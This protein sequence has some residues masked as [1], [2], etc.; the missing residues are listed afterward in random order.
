MTLLAALAVLGV[1]ATWAA[2]Q[3]FNT[4]LPVATGEFVF[5]EQLMYLNASDDPSPADRSLHV[6]G[7]ISVLGFGVTP[8]FA[9]FGAL[10]YLDK[11]LDI[12][13]PGLNEPAT[14][15]SSGLGDMRLFG[16]YTVFQEDARGRTFRI[17]PLF[18]LEVPSGEDDERDQLGRLPAPLQP[19]RGAR[20]GFAG[21][22]VTYQTLDYQVD[23]QLSYE[24]NAE[25]NGFELGDELRLD[26]SLQYRLWPREL[27]EGV[28]GFLYGVIE[29]NFLQQ[30]ENALAGLEDPNSGGRS[31]HLSPGVQYVTQRW[32]VE[33]I[34]QIPVAQ[35]L[36]G[37]AL[38][39]DFIFRTGFRFNF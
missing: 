17:A 8:R 25:A 35:D 37:A 13:L 20:A 10:P 9:V 7:A 21:V 32:I 3:T 5:R 19:G 18:G 2:P 28:P 12:S 39:E 1:E 11:E 34:V 30:D 29:A 23:A 14:R 6:T 16:R 26:A 31:W 4:A 15:R 33:G 22:V 38:A 36:N 24:N 27:G